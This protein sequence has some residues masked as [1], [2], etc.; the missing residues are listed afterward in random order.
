MLGKTTMLGRHKSN[1]LESYLGYLPWRGSEETRWEGPLKT[2][3]VWSLS[4]SIYFH[5][6]YI[7]FIN[8]KYFTRTKERRP[9]PP[10]PSEQSLELTLWLIKNQIS[11]FDIVFSSL[12][13]RCGPEICI[14][15]K[16]IGYAI[17]ANPET[18]LTENHMQK[19]TYPP[20]Y[21]FMF[22]MCMLF[23]YNRGIR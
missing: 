4:T 22:L 9:F 10:V 18:K 7:W 17:T 16:F 19:I 12:Q 15:N 21:L 2:V 3:K 1:H 11:G 8:R 14:S 20:W 6:I 23:S 5:R 13:L